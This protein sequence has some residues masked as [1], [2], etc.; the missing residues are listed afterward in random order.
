LKQL[1][2]RAKKRFGQHF[3]ASPGIVRQIITVAQLEA[4]CRV[5]EI[6]PGLGVLTEALLDCGASVTAVELD[7]DMAGFIRERLPAVHLIEGDGAQLDLPELLEG[8]GWR[9]VSNLPYNAGTRMITNMLNA[10][11]T[12]ER[13]VVMVQK[14]VADRLVAPAG[15]RKRGSLSVFTEARAQARIRIKVPPGAFHPPPKVRSAVV[16]MRL[17]PEA[18]TGPAPVEVF[19]QVV[20]RSFVQPRKTIRNNLAAA[21]SRDLADE[22][23]NEA[24]VSPSDRP[25]ALV[26]EQFQA[27]AVAVDGRTSD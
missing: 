4:G 26:L 20:R 27:L 25:A 16:D 22:V 18:N 5:L 19:D 12:F 2:A 6:G 15:H 23:L 9:C 14:E 13:L 24:G 1:E 8:S 3:L 7:R 21:Y 17:L 10:P 11:D